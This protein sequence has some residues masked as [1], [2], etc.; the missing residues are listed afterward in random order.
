MRGLKAVL[1]TIDCSNNKF[2]K[3]D[4]SRGCVKKCPKSELSSIWSLDKSGF[5]TVS[6][7]TTFQLSTKKSENLLSILKKKVD[8]LLTQF[9]VQLI[10]RIIKTN[11]PNK[12]TDKKSEFSSKPKFLGLFCR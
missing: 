5:W 9:L 4:N 3:H 1:S 12:G 7:K 11:F 10:G 8:G 6:H 2:I